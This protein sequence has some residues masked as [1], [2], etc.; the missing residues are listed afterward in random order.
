MTAPCGMPRRLFR[1]SVVR[2]FLPRSSVSSTGAFQ[3]CGSDGRLLPLSHLPRELAC[4]P[5]EVSH[6]PAHV[7]GRL[8]VVPVL[9]G[10]PVAE[11]RPRSGRAAVHAA[12]LHPADSGGHAGMA[13]A[14]RRTAAPARMHRRRVARA[15]HL[16]APGASEPAQSLLGAAAA[17]PRAPYPAG[18][19]SS[20]RRSPGRH[21]SPT[22]AAR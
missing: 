4:L 6:P 1:A 16:S 11:R 5:R 8:R 10:V 21:R 17:Q 15:C 12:T 3:P 2:V 13:D 14:R 9:E 22:R 19:A 7:H 18:I 20:C